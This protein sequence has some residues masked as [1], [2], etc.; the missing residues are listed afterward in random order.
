M[1]KGDVVLFLRLALVF[2]S[3]LMSWRKNSYIEKPSHEQAAY[4]RRIERERGFIYRELVA[5]RIA[6][7][8][9]VKPPLVLGDIPNPLP[10]GWTVTQ[11]RKARGLE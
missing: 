6:Q 3:F 11:Y 7:L 2:S 5:M 1:S 4:V 9:R 8:K 10:P